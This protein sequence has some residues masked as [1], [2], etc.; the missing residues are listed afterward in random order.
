MRGVN[1]GRRRAGRPGSGPPSEGGVQLAGQAVGPGGGVYWVVEVGGHVDAVAP[2]VP[3]GFWGAV[4]DDQ[5]ASRSCPALAGCVVVQ[6]E[7]GTR[8]AGIRAARDEGH[9]GGPDVGVPAEPLYGAAP[10]LD[11][12]FSA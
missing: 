7:L 8:V 11:V 1:G 10:H 4:G 2:A 5:D 12:R 6:P 9:S 3:A